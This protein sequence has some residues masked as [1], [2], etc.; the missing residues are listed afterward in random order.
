M[1]SILRR[2]KKIESTEQ[3]P[4]SSE[5]RDI[6]DKEVELKV[7]VNPNA[8][9]SD[10]K[11]RPKPEVPDVDMS[12]YQDLP[13][14]LQDQIRELMLKSIYDEHPELDPLWAGMDNEF[15][16]ERRSLTCADLNKLN[17]AKLVYSE[18]GDIERCIRDVEAIW[19]Q[20]RG[21]GLCS[22][23]RYYLVDLYAEADRI[24]DALDLLD[25]IAEEYPRDANHVARRKEEIKRN[26]GL[27]V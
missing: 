21:C 1:F 5:S 8:K 18:T 19:N 12:E 3:K 20:E 25:V 22:R 6:S 9:C 17:V 23:D 16:N 2:K 10:V 4:I 13:S 7:T 26:A 27:I 11:R 24:D 15:I 14:D